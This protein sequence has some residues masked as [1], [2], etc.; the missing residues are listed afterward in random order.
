MPDISVKEAMKKVIHKPYKLMLF[1]TVVGVCTC[2]RR[3]TA[4]SGPSQCHQ[5]PPHRY[6]HPDGQTG[7]ETA[8]TH[9]P[10]SY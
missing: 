9:Q 8:P 7:A 5:S 10:Q 2:Y 6:T 1:L 4:V 3:P